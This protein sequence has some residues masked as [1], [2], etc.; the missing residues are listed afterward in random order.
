[1]A[2]RLDGERQLEHDEVPEH[3]S[4]I[5]SFHLADSAGKLFELSYSSLRTLA[6]AEPHRVTLHEAR[7]AA[8]IRGRA[9]EQP[10]RCGRACWRARLPTCCGGA[11]LMPA[12][13]KAISLASPPLAAAP[14]RRV[15]PARTV[16]ADICYRAWRFCP[17]SSDP[18]STPASARAP[19]GR[20]IRVPV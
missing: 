10:K 9:R 11:A 17:G 20:R 15:R 1:M 13:S 19:P 2:D 6:S 14:A 8:D 7:S 18:Q 3:G 5:F 12:R 4:S 16:S